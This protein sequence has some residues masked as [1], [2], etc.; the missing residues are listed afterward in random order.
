MRGIQ[1]RHGCTRP[2]P[3]SRVEGEAIVRFCPECGRAAM[4]DR[5]TAPPVDEPREGGD[6]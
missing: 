6:G 2:R 3:E 5:R 1:H 4:Y